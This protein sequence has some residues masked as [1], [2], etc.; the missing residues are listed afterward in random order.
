MSDNFTNTD[1]P[2]LGG[3]NGF[4]EPIQDSDLDPE[5]GKLLNDVFEGKKEDDKT[6]GSDWKSPKLPRPRPKDDLK[7]MTQMRKEEKKD[8]FREEKRRY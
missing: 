3:S 1:P 7:L 8:K 5:T 6:F 2:T 4:E